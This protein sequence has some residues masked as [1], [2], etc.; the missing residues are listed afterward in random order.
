LWLEINDTVAWLGHHAAKILLSTVATTLEPSLRVNV[1]PETREL[2]SL[3]P[4]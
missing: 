2:L 3:R 4:R 1:T